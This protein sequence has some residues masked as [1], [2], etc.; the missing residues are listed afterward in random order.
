MQPAL[1]ST[2]A[3]GLLMLMGGQVSAMVTTSIDPE[4]QL[5]SWTLQE[6]AF[7]LQLIQRLPDQTRAF[8]MARGFSRTKSR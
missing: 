1:F 4:T 5:Q 6:G 8:Y 3:I 7:S 2:A